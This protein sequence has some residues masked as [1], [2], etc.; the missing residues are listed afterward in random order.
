MKKLYKRI[1]FVL[2]PILIYLVVFYVMEPYNYLGIKKTADTS[3]LVGKML[4]YKNGSYNGIL[5][6]DSR[7]AKYDVSELSD[8]TGCNFVN[9]AYG[10]SMTKEMASLFWWCMENKTNDIKEVIIVSGFYNMN[11]LL[12]QDRVESTEKVIANPFSFA[13]SVENLSATCSA[14]LDSKK[15]STTSSKSLDDLS[16]AERRDRVNSHIEDMRYYLEGFQYDMEVIGSLLEIGKYCADNNI[17]VSLIVPP[18]Y[19]SF[20]EELA[21]NDLLEDVDYYKETISKNML[22]YDMEYAEC[23]LSN[24]ISDYIDS[25][26]FRGK[27]FDL[28]ADVI[29]DRDLTHARLWK[30]GNTTYDNN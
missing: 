28:F 27:T 20:Y 10:G 9:L 8:R 18:W 14:I 16:D 26:H 19:S 3:N 13:F 21:A 11:T 2:I 15:P 22:V 4:N 29:V 7:V 1:S 5:L 6:G 12:Q 24:D 25:S 30:N 17:N 23:P